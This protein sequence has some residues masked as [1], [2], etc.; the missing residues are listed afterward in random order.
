MGSLF[1]CSQSLEAS[2][3]YHNLVLLTLELRTKRTNFRTKTV[4]KSKNYRHLRVS[5]RTPRLNIN[6]R[7]REQYEK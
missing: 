2:N 5:S 7:M 1:F 3:L 6:E 4:D